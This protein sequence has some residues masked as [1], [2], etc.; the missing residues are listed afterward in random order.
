MKRNIGTADRIVRAVVGTAII[1][2]G[3]YYRS[4]WG[5]LGLV[6]LITAAVGVCPPYWLLGISTY[7]RDRMSGRHT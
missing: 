6:P 1:G 5:A 7:F 2:A 3:I 4:W